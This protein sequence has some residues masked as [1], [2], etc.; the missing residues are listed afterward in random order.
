VKKNN[1]QNLKSIDALEEISRFTAIKKCFYRN[2]R[3]EGRDGVK[4]KL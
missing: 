4:G 3:G 1:K 2:H